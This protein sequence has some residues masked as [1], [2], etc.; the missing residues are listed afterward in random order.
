MFEHIY[1]PNVFLNK[2]YK[3]LANNGGGGADGV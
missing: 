1:N 2:C 3:I